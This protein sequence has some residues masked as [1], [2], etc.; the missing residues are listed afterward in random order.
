MINNM[1]AKSIYKSAEHPLDIFKAS[2]ECSAANTRHALAFVVGTQGGAVRNPG[3]VMLVTESGQTLGYVSGG[4]I[5]ADVRAQAIEA[6]RTNATKQIKYGLGSKYLDLKLPCGGA[7][8]ISICPAPNT[9]ALNSVISKIETRQITQLTIAQNGQLYCESQENGLTFKYFP[10]L[11][12]RIAGR[13]HDPQAL[14]RLAVASGI[15]VT[16]QSPDQE[17]LQHLAAD[18]KTM[19]LTSPSPAPENQDDEWTAF[20]LMF[21]DTD[22]ETTLLKQALTGPAFYVGAVGSRRTHTIRC[23]ALAEHGLSQ[24][25]IDR[26][27]APIGVI[28]ALRDASMIAISALAEIIGEY[29]KQLQKD[30]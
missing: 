18:I 19:H 30:L 5:D 25:H 26:I 7:I 24:I 6:I 20:T 10:K 17:D 23:R 14:A 13:G 28:P 3:A 2:V 16:L 12:L 11:K 1:V 15:D 8:D 4:C 21:H 27:F 9:E 29:Q 22:W